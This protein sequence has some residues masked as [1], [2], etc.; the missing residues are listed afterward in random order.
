MCLVLIKIPGFTYRRSSQTDLNQNNEKEDIMTVKI[1]IKRKFKNANS[2]N[3]TE[4]LIESRKN[5]MGEKG[6]ISS[7]SL[8]SCDDPNLILVLSIWQ[9]KEDWENYLNSPMRKETELRYTELLENPTE[10]EFFNVGLPFALGDHE[11]VEPL[12]F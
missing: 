5:A 10:Y 2:K 9:K 4:M 12:E 6:Y 1:L 7:E 8:C 11:F 3:V